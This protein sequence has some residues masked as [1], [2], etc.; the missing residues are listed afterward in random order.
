M[1]MCS[2]VHVWKGVSAEPGQPHPTLFRF[3]RLQQ[4][5][6][7][8][9]VHI[10]CS[11][12]INSST[13][14][15]LGNACL[16]DVSVH[17]RDLCFDMIPAPTPAAACSCPHVNMRL[18]SQDRRNCVMHWLSQL[19]Q[20]FLLS[21]TLAQTSGITLTS[22]QLSGCKLSRVL[23]QQQSAPWEEGLSAS[24]ALAS[25]GVFV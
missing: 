7:T 14:Y 9:T 13:C 20:A 10:C 11:A 1:Y 6:R 21:K 19:Q 24:A 4:A 12:N 15:F 22:N 5:C 8:C 17:G 18:C 23:V 25:S 2:F 3:A 16:E